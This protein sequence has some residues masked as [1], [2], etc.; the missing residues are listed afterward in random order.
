MNKNKFQFAQTQNLIKYV[1][2]EY[3]RD[4]EFLWGK[5]PKAAVWRRQDNG[6]WFGLLAE[7]NIS[8]ICAGAPDKTVEILNLRCAPDV[9]DCIADNKNIFRGWHMNKQHWIT[10]VLDG[11]MKMPQIRHLLDASYEIASAK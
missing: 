7:I 11:R 3:G 9:I 8:K 2:S 10:L 6:K 4:L 5:L 1:A